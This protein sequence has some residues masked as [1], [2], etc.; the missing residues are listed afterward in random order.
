[1][2]INQKIITLTIMG[3]IGAGGIGLAHALIKYEK[4]KA[5]EQEAAWKQQEI[6]MRRDVKGVYVGLNLRYSGM[7]SDNRF[8]VARVHTGM[9]LNAFYSTA[10]EVITIEGKRFRI[11]SVTPKELRLQYMGSK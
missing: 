9:D 3:A 4:N 6:V 11:K 10:E 7:P 8:A 1:M 5:I 2:T